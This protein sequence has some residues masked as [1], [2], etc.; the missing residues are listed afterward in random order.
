M[1]TDIVSN[2][3]LDTAYD[4]LI[5]GQMAETYDA[6]LPESLSFSHYELAEN[7][8]FTPMYWKKFL[9]IKEVNRAI[10]GEV[11]TIGEAAARKAMERLRSGKAQSSD[12]SAAKELFANSKILKEKMNNSQKIVITRIPPKKEVVEHGE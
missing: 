4:R 10:E 9:K 12:V 7:Y 1:F 8:G 11:A 3:E 2:I 6:H 5:I